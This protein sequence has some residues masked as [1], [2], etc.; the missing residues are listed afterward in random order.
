MLDDTDDNYDF[1]L[2]DGTVDLNP[3]QMCID[4][5]SSVFIDFKENWLPDSFPSPFE[6][7]S[8]FDLDDMLKIM[9]FDI[10]LNRKE[11]LVQDRVSKRHRSPRLFEFLILLLGKSHYESYASF[12]DR[13]KG[14]FQIHQPAKVAELWQAVKSRQ[15]NQKMTYDKFARAIRWYYKS[16]IM[17]KTNTRY[18]FK[19]SPETLRN[20]IIDE[21]N[22]NRSAC[23]PA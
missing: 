23:I 7:D 10:P 15:S 18:T 1:M 8:S 4:A 3:D 2:F 13:S 20:Y 6:L 17:Q 9:S 16:N 21:N 22:N 14:L 11:W 5:D 19:F 12:C